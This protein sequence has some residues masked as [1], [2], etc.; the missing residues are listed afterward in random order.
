[1]LPIPLASI[2][3]RRPHAYTYKTPA[4][5]DRLIAVVSL[6]YSIANAICPSLFLGE[7]G[8]VPQY[9]AAHRVNRRWKSSAS[10]R[11]S[12]VR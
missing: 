10:D 2:A 3:T 7:P 1:M 8:I 6:Y 4:C 9:L 12:N 11:I 5:K